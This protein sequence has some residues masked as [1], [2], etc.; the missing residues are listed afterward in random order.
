MAA[1][2]LAAGSWAEA[3]PVW[4]ITEHGAKPGLDVA[5]VINEGLRTQ[6]EHG[7][8]VH[9]PAGRW[10]IGSTIEFPNRAGCVLTGVGA[11]GDSANDSLRGMSTVLE[12]YGPPDTPMIQMIGA[13]CQ[14]EG[15]A[16]R[17][18]PFRSDRPRAAI[19]ILI[20]KTQR[21]LGGGKHEFRSVTL[22]RC[23]VG[24]QCGLSPEEGN[25]D[26]LGFQRLVFDACDVGYRVVNS[27]SMSH[28]ID[29]LEARKTPVVFQFYGG[30]ML[31]AR[32][33]S[34]FKSTLLELKR[35]SP[36]RYSTGRNN[37]VFRFENMKV[38]AKNAGTFC[39]VDAEPRIHAQVIVDCAMISGPSP[40]TLARLRG[41]TQLVLRDVTSPTEQAQIE[42]TD[43][44]VV[45]MQN[46]RVR[47][48][49]ADDE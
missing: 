33:L 1:A 37:A 14:I 46:V 10:G 8:A 19:G 6:H 47:G 39:V 20:T 13:R 29:R 38:D 36:P 34:L 49:V 2:G 43:D 26:L 5:A 35:N 40:F 16:I 27:Q 9:I 17:G 12:W 44:A 15:V 45:T 48:L 11:A 18:V 3:Q 4:D 25:N 30:G 23:S 42:R 24:V 41:P 22:S 28:W 7:L 31:H 32:N 21:G